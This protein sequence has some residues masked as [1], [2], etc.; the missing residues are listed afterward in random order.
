MEP[1]GGQGG[2][3]RTIGPR[4]AWFCQNCG[5]ALRG[6]GSFC[7]C[8]GQARPEGLIEESGDQGLMRRLASRIS[9]LLGRR[10]S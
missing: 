4:T 9:G 2:S 7:N 5:A 1:L 6:P 8:G 10:Q 3:S